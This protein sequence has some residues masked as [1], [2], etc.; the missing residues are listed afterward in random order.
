MELIDIVRALLTPAEFKV[1]LQ[2]YKKRRTVNMRLRKKLFPG[3]AVLW[4][5]V[6]VPLSM[7]KGSIKNAPLVRRGTKSYALSFENASMMYIEPQGVNLSQFATAAALNNMVKIG[8][9]AVKQFLDFYQMQLATTTDSTIEALCAQALTG[10]ISYPMMTEGGALTKFDVDYGETQEQI[11]EVKLN[12]TNATIVDVFNLLQAMDKK[13][14]K[15]GFGSKRETLAGTK[16]FMQILKLATVTKTNIFKV[17]VKE[18]VVNVGG[19]LIEL[20]NGEYHSGDDAEGEQIM[21]P[22]IDE[23]SL[24]MFDPSANKF[25]YTALDDLDANLQALPIYMKPVK[26]E[27]P[28]GIKILS[29]SKPLPAVNVDSICW[30]VDL[31]SAPPAQE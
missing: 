16:V 20:E 21:T 8:K 1:W 10:K 14:K 13:L 31:F 27:D 7:L 19:Y 22:N 26:Q 30:G 12:D 25:F 29:M 9:L 6:K 4:P 5:D 17:E 2:E 15:K 18:N 23:E 11:A 28:N 24:V 3:D